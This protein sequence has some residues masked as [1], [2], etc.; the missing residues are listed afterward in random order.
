MMSGGHLTNHYYN[1]GD[2]E[3]WATVIEREA[4]PLLAEQMHD[5]YKL[6]DRYDYYLSG[7]IGEVAIQSE[8]EAYRDKWYNVDAEKLRRMM[9]EK[10]MAYCDS[11]VY[12]YMRK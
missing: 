2:L 10:C 3:D 1:L 5:L 8:W 4:N 12:G 9:L 11:M 7:D 6:L